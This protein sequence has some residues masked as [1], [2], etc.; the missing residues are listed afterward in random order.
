[1]KIINIDEMKIQDSNGKYYI[2]TTG[3]EN[4]IFNR[5]LTEFDERENRTEETNRL[6]FKLYQNCPNPFEN[7]TDIQFSIPKS[8]IV[9]LSLF[10]ISGKHI[11]V[12][13]NEFKQGGIYNTK[14]DASGLQSGTYFCKLIHKTMS[15]DFTDIKKIDIS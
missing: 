3:N 9:E 5:I 8:G 12:L 1:M 11:Q 13:L 14:F 4:G 7:V 10:D 2:L 15:E 6:K